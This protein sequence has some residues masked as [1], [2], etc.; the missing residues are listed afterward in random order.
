MREAKQRQARF[1]VT[2]QRQSYFMKLIN[3]DITSG[4]IARAGRFSLGLYTGYTATRLLL[5]WF[6]GQLEYSAFVLLGLHI[7]FR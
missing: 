2:P 1:R 4:F 6:S 5:F 3:A 7:P